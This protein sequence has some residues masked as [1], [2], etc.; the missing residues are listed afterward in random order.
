MPANPPPASRVPRNR[1]MRS[2]RSGDGPTGPR[3]CL[4]LGS[5]PG[6]GGGRAGGGDCDPFGGASLPRVEAPRPPPGCRDS[7]RHRPLPRLER[8]A[9]THHPP[10][11]DHLR[12]KTGRAGTSLAVLTAVERQRRWERRGC[13]RVERTVDC[14]FP[15]WRWRLVSRKSANHPLY[16]DGRGTRARCRLHASLVTEGGMRVK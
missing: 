13:L 3:A 16:I 10:R 14:C 6:C 5:R 12:R 2:A 7:R 8:Q 15:T 4:R 9:P 11:A 1:W